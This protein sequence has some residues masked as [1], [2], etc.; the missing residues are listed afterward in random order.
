MYTN[1][2]KLNFRYSQMNDDELPDQM[3]A[4]HKSC[5]N[6][7]SGDTTSTRA[8]EPRDSKYN[9]DVFDKLLVLI[10]MT[11]YGRMQCFK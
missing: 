3:K 6:A 4:I 5:P 9:R 2:K 11:S 8:W 1:K 7:G 10:I